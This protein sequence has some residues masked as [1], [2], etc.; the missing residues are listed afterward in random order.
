MKRYLKT[1]LKFCV[2]AA[3]FVYI[4]LSNDFLQVWEFFIQI[5]LSTWV[6]VLFL[7]VFGVIIATVRLS[8]FFKNLSFYTLMHIRLLSVAYGFILPGQA[9]EEG[10]KAY[11]LGKEGKDYGQSGAAV[12]LDKLVGVIAV[13]LLGLVG[14]LCTRALGLGILVVFIVACILLIALAL[15]INISVLYT[16]A[17]KLIL[18]LS[19][20]MKK[21]RKLFAFVL[22]VLDN[23]RTF[24]K[25]KRLLV[26]NIVYGLLYQLSILLTGALL[27]HDLGAGFILMDW[28]WI[29]AVITIVLILPLSLG[30]LGV[31]EVSMIGLL[32][33]VGVAPE[34]ALAVSFGFLALMLLQAIVG[35]GMEVGMTLRRTK[36]YDNRDS[37]GE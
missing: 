28:L 2:T 15:S 19:K 37:E 5:S 12:M 11:L 29:H 10:V 35:I 21:L 34:Q 8:L 36:T 24:A 7:L 25:N 33:L 14:V 1:I 31:R 23:W 20:K 4:I 26:F 6:I 9:A 16:K 27:T 22:G 18:W 3:L 32:G 13:L 17:S 30:G